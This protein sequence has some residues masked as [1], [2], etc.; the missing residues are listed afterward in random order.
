MIVALLTG[1]VTVVAFVVGQFVT[2]A[3][4][5]G[6]G[7]WSKPAGGKYRRANF[8]LGGVLF[9]SAAFATGSPWLAA[10]ALGFGLSAILYRA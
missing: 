10:I 5:R 8:P 7:W 3:L 2:E 1:V 4:V 6:G 9:G